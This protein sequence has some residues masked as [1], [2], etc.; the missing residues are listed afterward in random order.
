MSATDEE[1]A[2]PVLWRTAVGR[3]AFDFEIA[4]RANLWG[5]YFANEDYIAGVAK[6]LR[7]VRKGLNV[8]YALT[9]L[10]A[11]LI[12]SGGFRSE[13]QVALFGVKLP[14]QVLSQQALAAIMSAVFARYVTCFISLTLLHA[15]LAGLLPK[16]GPPCWEYMLARY[17]GFNVY[18]TL[19]RPKTIGYS[20]P[21]REIAI[22]AVVLLMSLLTILIHVGL[23]TTA[24]IVALRSALSADSGVAITLGLFS[25]LGTTVAT[26]AMVGA[27]FV[28]LP[29]R[30][31]AS[32]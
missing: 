25:L 32:A 17:D 1:P 13:A 29:Y 9:F 22:I 30:L 24:S 2:P 27:V 31:N 18:T 26:I 12:L 15:G 16:F 5:S 10:L 21:K 7:T 4:T 19:L 28:P 14:L 6:E 3:A 23:V 11:F 8:A 20:S